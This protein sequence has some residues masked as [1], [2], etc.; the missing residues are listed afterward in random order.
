MAGV[1]QSSISFSSLK[2]SYVAGGGNDASGNSSLSD[3]KTNTSIS[4]SDFRNAGFTNG[5]SVPSGSD[6]ISINDNFKGKTFGSSSIIYGTGSFRVYDNWSAYPTKLKGTSGSSTFTGSTTANKRIKLYSGQS[7]SYPYSIILLTPNATNS[8]TSPGLIV[9]RTN[10][11]AVDEATVWFRVVSHNMYS[12]VQMGIVAKDMTVNNWTNQKGDLHNK[13]ATFC[14]RLCF[15]GFGYHNYAGSRDDITSG[16]TIVS[17]Q[18]KTGKYGSSLTTNFHNRTGATAGTM[19]SGNAVSA[20]PGGFN[21]YF[22][23]NSYANYSGYRSNTLNPNH[24]IKIK[25]YETTLQVKLVSGSSNIVPVSG[26]WSAS[27]L[28]GIFSGMYVSGTGIPTGDG[29]F[30]GDI[31]TNYMVL[32]KGKGTTSLEKLDVSSSLDL[33]NITL[34]ISGYLYWTLT[35]G[36][37]SSNSNTNYTNAKI[38]GPPHTVLPK[39]QAA[40][41]GSTTSVEIKEW[42]FCI[43]DTTSGTSNYFDYDL[44]DTD[45]GGTAF[46]YSVTYGTGTVPSST[47]ATYSWK[48]YAYGADIGTT[49]LYWYSGTTL[50]L[51]RSIV[52][53]QHTSS[54]KTWNSYTEDLSSYS[55]QT[56]YIVYAYK[57]GSSWMNDPQFDEMS[58]EIAGSQT[59]LAPGLGLWSRNTSDTPSLSYPSSN[60]SNISLPSTSTSKKWNLDAGGTPSS[61]T[62]TT[63]DASGSSTGK[64]LYFEGSSP[65]FNTSNSSNKYYWFRSK[66]QFTLGDAGD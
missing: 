47:Q 17:P 31:H 54:G 51:L 36:S 61:S 10:A 18:Y 6:E 15:H 34:T 9:D 56:G 13:H 66:N 58:I 63:V 40:S 35:T 64:Y 59:D 26:N 12:Q 60:W 32:Y 42:A 19:R 33:S 45:P 41:S 38:F 21:M 62:G 57:T 29:A 52:G 1:D 2:A 46:S 25:W 20:P 65:N 5:T 53:Q 27:D 8:S 24:G 49:Y 7:G 16:S 44:R 50:N 14:D 11:D 43:G 48:Y 28:T 30:I 23:K 37:D 22:F 39:Y 55:G 4:L 3:G